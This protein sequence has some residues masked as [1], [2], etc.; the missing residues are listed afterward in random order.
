MV[1]LGGLVPQEGVAALA[2]PR[3]GFIGLWSA[4]WV[5]GRGALRVAAVRIPTHHMHTWARAHMEASEARA[6]PPA[7][8]HLPC[9]TP[10]PLPPSHIA[11]RLCVLVC[12]VGVARGVLWWQA[13]ETRAHIPSQNT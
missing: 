7:H 3:Q 8:P 9:H 2:P 12:G 13:P 11:C 10:V 6:R 1:W 4:P 5:G